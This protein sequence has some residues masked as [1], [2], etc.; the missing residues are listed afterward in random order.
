MPS[1]LNWTPKT[2]MLSD[3][4]AETVV[5]PVTVVFAEGAVR[6]MVGDVVSGGV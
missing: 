2:P 6:E 4:V 5:V 3:A 1:N